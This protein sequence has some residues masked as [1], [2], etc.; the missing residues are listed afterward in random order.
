MYSDLNHKVVSED[1][2]KAVEC[3]EAAEKAGKEPCNR[4][5]HSVDHCDD[6][7]YRCQ[8]IENLASAV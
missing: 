3:M 8:E 1:H 7:P 2:F 4:E 6:C 5:T